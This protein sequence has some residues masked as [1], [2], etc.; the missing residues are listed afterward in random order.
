MLACVS[1][2]QDVSSNILYSFIVTLFMLRITL[3]RNNEFVALKILRGEYII[4]ALFV[5]FR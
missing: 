4:T 2:S 3:I 5:W 1:L